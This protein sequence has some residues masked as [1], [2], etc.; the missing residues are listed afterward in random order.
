MRVARVDRRAHRTRRRL[1][2][3]RWTFLAL[4]AYVSCVVLVAF[5]AASALFVMVETIVGWVSSLLSS[6][7]PAL[8]TVDNSW[9]WTVRRACSHNRMSCPVCAGS[10]SLSEDGAECVVRC[11][12]CQTTYY[13]DGVVGRT[14]V[15]EERE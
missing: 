10:R 12:E 9:E 1:R 2:R 5:V 14:V 8:C 6:I 15:L 11:Q 7:L 4:L 13:Y 3:A